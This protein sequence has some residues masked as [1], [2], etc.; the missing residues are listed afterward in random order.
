MAATNLAIGNAQD[1]ST[2]SPPAGLTTVLVIGAGLIGTSVALAISRQGVKVHLRDTDPSAA[3]TAQALG[4]G[5][6]E[7]PRGPVDLAV[8]AVPPA[9]MATELAAAQAAGAARAYTDVSSVKEAVEQASSDAGCDMSSYLG[10]HPMAGRERSG[11]WAA[12]PGLFEGRPW[13]ITPT[14]ATSAVTERSVRELI[15]LCGAVPVVMA[16]DAHD[17]AMAL[18]SHTPHLI[19]ALTA[20]R[21]E[22]L[23]QTE[24]MLVGQGLQDVV[25]IS[26]GDPRLWA[27]ILV[28][29][30]GAVAGVLGEIALDLQRVTS[31]LLAVASSCPSMLAQA[32]EEATVSLLDIL[33]RGR[34][35][36]DRLP[37]KHG[38][39]RQPF[40]EV[41]VVVGD[42]SGALARL[43]ADV[44]AAGVNVEDIVLDHAMGTPSGTVS[45]QVS[46]AA[47]AT[48]PEA[49]QA[50]G[51]EAYGPL[52]ELH[53]RNGGHHQ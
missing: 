50:L 6:V 10:G 24:M 33:G 42:N 18:V 16:A 2:S 31:A 23:G 5:T 41:H 11:P 32:W 28:S 30:A 52:T 53:R 29:N 4:A 3:L 46:S 39:P 15:A 12:K 40:A 8:V 51:W 34:A 37:G 7:Q 36:H 49:L 25:R 48:L 44:S 26:G 19:S 22:H 38:S 27:D 13:I 35:G 17:R 14:R 47:S 45:L 21:L 20:A 1:G 9:Q 43:L